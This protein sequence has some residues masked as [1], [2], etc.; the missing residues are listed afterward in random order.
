MNRWSRLCSWMVVLL[1]LIPTVQAP[2]MGTANCTP[3]EFMWG[4]CDASPLE[5]EQEEDLDFG[6]PELHEVI[7]QYPEFIRLPAEY[8]GDHYSAPVVLTKRQVMVRCDSDYTDLFGI[9]CMSGRTTEPVTMWLFAG[10]TLGL[11]SLTIPSA[12]PGNKKPNKAKEF[13][14]MV[15]KAAPPGAV[16]S[17]MIT[18]YLKSAQ[19]TWCTQI[20]DGVEYRPA[21]WAVELASGQVAMGRLYNQAYHLAKDGY[22]VIV[23]R[24][25]WKRIRVWTPGSNGLANYYHADSDVA[26]RY[27]QAEGRSYVP[28]RAINEAIGA[29]VS[30]PPGAD[31]R[32]LP[33][34]EMAGTTVQFPLDEGYYLVNGERADM[35]TGSTYLNEAS[36]RTMV[37]IRYALAPFGFEAYWNQD[38]KAALLV[39]R[40]LP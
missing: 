39:R 17:A 21:Q 23:V 4:M 37:P 34:I 26:M 10:G 3:Q 2:A 5:G 1:L 25:T 40:L 13:I 18:C 24:H 29:K 30:A 31:G 16:V 20:R 8:D 19:E 7:R 11:G 38:L 14:K 35:Q 33:T 28:L 36:G 6:D 22:W 32:R 15:A 27:H 9:T 12:D